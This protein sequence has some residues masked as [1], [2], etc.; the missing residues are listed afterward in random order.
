MPAVFISL[1]GERAR[2]EA[3]AAAARWR[4]G[5]PLSMFDGVPLAWKDLFDVAGSVTTAGAAYRRN[6]PA[7]LLDAPTVGLL[8]RE[9]GISPRA[10]G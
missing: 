5:Q 3:E 2:R 9:E 1:T 6:A 7:A 4:A 10:S 8:C